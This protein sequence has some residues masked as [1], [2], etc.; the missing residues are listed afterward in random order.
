MTDS[1]NETNGHLWQKWAGV[2][3]VETLLTR[4]VSHCRLFNETSFRAF[5]GHC[6]DLCE[7][8]L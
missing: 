8:E 4:I 5:L 3:V 2:V 7:K 1:L 6:W